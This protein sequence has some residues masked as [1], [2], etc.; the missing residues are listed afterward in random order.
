MGNAKSIAGESYLIFGGNSFTNS[1]LP[2]N[3]GTSAADTI[4]GT[5]AAEILNGGDSNDTLLG[6]GG[7]DVLLGGRGNDILAV[8]DL[9]FK[10]IVGGNGTD[11][12]RLD[13]SGL[14]LDLTTI[15]DNRILG[16]EQINITGSGNN[17]LTL[18]AR[19]VLNLS[20]E[21]NTLVVRRDSGDTVNIGSGWTTGANETMG[22]ETFEVFS[23]G[24]QY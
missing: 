16:I 1:I 4:T 15:A 3:L 20:D 14:T 24:L 18:T 2:A 8:S 11:T 10:R 21:S 17:T 5:A 23:Q 12:L 9:N 6:G 7:A 19:E 22:D 13:V